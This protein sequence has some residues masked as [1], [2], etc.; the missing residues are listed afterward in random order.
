MKIAALALAFL[1]TCSLALAGNRLDFMFDKVRFD[2]CKGFSG[3]RTEQSAAC[4]LYMSQY[5]AIEEC[6]VAS[7]HEHKLPGL[8]CLASKFGYTDPEAYGEELKNRAGSCSQ[9][10]DEAMAKYHGEEPKSRMKMMAFLK[11]VVVNCGDW[12]PDDFCSVVGGEHGERAKK[13][14]QML[15]TMRLPE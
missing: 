13:L 8:D 9:K 14:F 6:T 15:T 2:K 12:G 5:G 10:L 11:C 4:H 7:K 3:H 1:A